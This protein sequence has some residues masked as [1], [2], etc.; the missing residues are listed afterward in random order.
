[1]PFSRT[2]RVTRLSGLTPFYSVKHVYYHMC[3]CVYMPM[4]I[5]IYIYI[6]IEREREAEIQK[7]GKTY[8]QMADGAS[9]FGNLGQSLSL[10]TGV[11]YGSAIQLPP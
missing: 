10:Y 2:D 11:K 3:V 4:Y 7:W 5:Y 9:T 8:L 1:M 6:Y